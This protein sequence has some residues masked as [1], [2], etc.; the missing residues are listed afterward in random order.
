M[1]RINTG[2][3][4]EDD[5]TDVVLAAA[6]FI[7]IFGSGTDTDDDNV[8]EWLDGAVV[9]DGVTGCTM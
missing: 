1:I 9:D 3:I 8:K 4:S 5:L 2:K 6:A 7:E